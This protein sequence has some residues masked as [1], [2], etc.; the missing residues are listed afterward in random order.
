MAP[1]IALTFC[2]LFII[3]LFIIDLKRDTHTSS[4]L[5]LPF[6][7][8]I[9]CGSRLPSQWLNLNEPSREIDYLMS[10]DP[11]DRIF[12][13]LFIF[14]G[15]VIL[16]QRH[17][18]ISKIF[19]NNFWLMLLIAYAG[20]S[21]LWSDF[22]FVS[23]KRWIRNVVHILMVLIIITEPS[24]I[25]SLKTIIRRCAYVLIPLSITFIKYFRDIGVTYS[26]WG[27]GPLY[28]GATLGKNALGRLCL[29][30]G[31]CF[32]IDILINKQRFLKKKEVLI[33]LVLLSMIG[34]LFIKANS[35]TSAVSFMLGIFIFLSLKRSYFRRNIGKAVII[36]IIIIITLQM[37]FDFYDYLVILLER[38]VT[39]TGRTELWQDLIAM[40][41]N[42]LFGVG[43]ESFWLGDRMQYLWDKKQ[44]WWHPSEAH[45]GYLE[46]YLELGIIGI[47][48]L[49]A[50]IFSS[51]KK[52]SEAVLVDFESGRFMM[53]FFF[54]AL[55]Y[56]MTE[57]AFKGVHLMYFIFLIVIVKY[58]SFSKFKFSELTSHRNLP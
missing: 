57:A 53:T 51:Y 46:I 31:L 29:I 13:I 55:F 49:I 5:W 43:Y 36:I 33:N 28:I 44:Y 56:N 2:I 58:P 14:L 6:V 32:S 19:K 30:T 10:G 12:Y 27:E 16:S 4:A 42:S 34:W 23:F 37:S 11:L 47:A 1:N 45:N 40:T 15:L 7:W 54:I 39:L 41:H 48:L 35:A 52:L 26:P 50:V 3:F 20:V 25:E 18:S 9:I 38:D 8:F 21:I 22:M 17:L 24:P